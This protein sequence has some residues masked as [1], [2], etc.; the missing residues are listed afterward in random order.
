MEVREKPEDR[1]KSGNSEQRESFRT[2]GS[3]GK[4]EE[5]ESRE[6]LCKRESLRTVES[7]GKPEDMLTANN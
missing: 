5:G 3:Q 4:P 6:I 1:G 7:Q 2:C